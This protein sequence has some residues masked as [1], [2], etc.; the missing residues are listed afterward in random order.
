MW[1]NIAKPNVLLMVHFISPPPAHTGDNE[2]L[3]SAGSSN[4]INDDPAAHHHT[5]SKLMKH[6]FN[7]EKLQPLKDN[8]HP[9]AGQQ[10][11]YGECV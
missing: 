10:Q 8:H 3:V 11:I 2:S 7:E 4:S 9:Y 5:H 1:P 6:E